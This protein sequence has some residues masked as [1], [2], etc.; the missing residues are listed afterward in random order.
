M[1]FESGGWGN[2]RPSALLVTEGVCS[3]LPAPL[4]RPPLE[5][6]LGGGTFPAKGPLSDAEDSLSGFTCPLVISP[7]AVGLGPSVKVGLGSAGRLLTVFWGLSLLYDGSK[8]SFLVPSRNR[9]VDDTECLLGVGVLMC[10]SVGAK[11]LPVLSL[12]HHAGK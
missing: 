5:S 1:G 10:L 3:F 8:F 11:V 9:F 2:L 12:N 6:P 7:S 4:G